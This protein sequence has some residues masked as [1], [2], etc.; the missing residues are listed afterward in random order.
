MAASS[1]TFCTRPTPSTGGSGSRCR[2]YLA[3]G[4]LG[5]LLALALALLASLQP[6]AQALGLGGSRVHCRSAL[7]VA[8]PWPVGGSGSGR[9]ALFAKRRTTLSRRKDRGSAGAGQQQ[10][11]SEEEEE[12]DG[13]VDGQV[14]VP[15]PVAVQSRAA[16]AAATSEFQ[17]PAPVRGISINDQ[18]QSDISKFEERALQAARE[19]NSNGGA[20][21]ENGAVSGLKSVFSAVLIADFFVVIFFLVWFL[22]AAALQSTN[23]WL[24]ERFQDIFQPVVVPSLTVL[25]VGSIASGTIGG[26]SKSE[27]AK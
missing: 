16:T 12:E 25:M 17:Q 1:T 4:Q 21:E 9:T 26:G 5:L 11:G 3:S 22:A 6:A 18:L 27:D 2:Y 8:R 7:S 23:P 20:V 24:L 10:N 19:R 14:A 15:V 13:D